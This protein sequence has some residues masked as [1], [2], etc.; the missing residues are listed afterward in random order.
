MDYE[1]W[2]SGRVK[3]KSYRLSNL[4]IGNKI[5]KGVTFTVGS[6]ADRIAALTAAKFAGVNV[7]SRK[8]KGLNGQKPNGFTIYFLN[9]NA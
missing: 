9:P 4:A 5:R 2:Q 3:T 1:R 6:N 7:S 8:N